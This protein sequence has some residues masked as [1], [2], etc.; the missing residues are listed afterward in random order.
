[1]LIS[2]ALIIAASEGCAW[3]SLSGAPLAGTPEEPGLL[4]VL[5]TRLGEEMEPLYGFR[6]LA[7]S[8]RKFQPEEHK[9]YLAY[10]DELALPAIG[11]AVVHAYVPD[12]RAADA[13][14]AVKT[15]LAERRQALREP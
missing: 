14:R 6:S 8:K 10:N 7:A 5:L 11:L 2:E 3:I 12:M 4:D 9:W 15:W 13:A 1:M